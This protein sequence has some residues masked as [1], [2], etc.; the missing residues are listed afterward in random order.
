MREEAPSKFQPGQKVWVLSDAIGGGIN[1][2]L[3]AEGTAYHHS[4]AV[5]ERT[6]YGDFSQSMLI[7]ET[8]WKL[9]AATKGVSG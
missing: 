9:I 1:W 2:S 5:M 8:E 7:P 6:N 3:T 4:D